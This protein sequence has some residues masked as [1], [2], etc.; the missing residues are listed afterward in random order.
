[1]GSIT[2]YD[3][4]KSS[5]VVIYAVG[6]LELAAFDENLRALGGVDGGQDD[7]RLIFSAAHHKARARYDVGLEFVHTEVAGV[8][9]CQERRQ[10]LALGVEYV[11]LQLGEE[12]DGGHYGLLV[13]L[14]LFP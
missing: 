8:D 12:G 5:R 4:V 11:A 7:V 6:A 13:E 2:V 10:G 3:E 14:C 1:M 9:L